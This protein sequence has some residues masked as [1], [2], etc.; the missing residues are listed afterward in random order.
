MHKPL[1][2]VGPLPRIDDLL[3]RLGVS[4]YFSKLDLKSGYHQ[5]E[6][7]PRDQYKTAFKTRSG[8]FEWAGMPFGLTK[9]PTTFQAAMMMEFR[10]MLDLF[11]L[12]Y[13]SDILVS[14]RTLDKHLNHLRTVLERLRMTKYKANCDK[15]EF[16]QQEL[17][18]LGQF[19]A[20]QGIHPLGDKIQAIQDWSEPTNTTDV[21]SFLGLADY[22]QRFIKGYA[23]VAAPLTRLQSPKLPFEFTDEVRAAFHTL[24]MTMLM[25]PVLRI[26]DPTLPTRVTTDASGYD[27]GA[28][29]EQHEDTDW[30]AVEFFSQKVPPRNS[31]DDL[32]KELLDFVTIHLRHFLLKCELHPHFV[33][34]YKSDPEYATL[35][36]NLSWDHPPASH[37]PCCSTH[38][39]KTCNAFRMIV[40][41]G[42]ASSVS[43]M[44]RDSLATLEST[45]QLHDYVSSFDGP[46]SFAMSHGIASL[47]RFAAG[48]SPAIATRRASY[49]PYRSYENSERQLSWTLPTLL[50]VIE[51]ATIVFSQ[52]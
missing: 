16:A 13:L 44:T 12:I 39:S 4:T 9:A 33:R 41:Y 22:Y 3:E 36:D 18:Y 10:D 14:S 37:Y 15:C 48:T 23:R 28:V 2:N 47:A 46:T 52:L 34:D 31:F 43:F 50:L 7:L 45:V 51:S 5:M 20:L 40:G 21:R 26:Y 38:A 1:K 42:L 32:R 25:A 11:V 8:H 29:L 49:D 30:H 27:I 35:Y 19:V 17:E 24:K 6:I